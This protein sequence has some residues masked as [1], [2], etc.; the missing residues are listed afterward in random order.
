[1]ENL[2]YHQCNGADGWIA[3]PFQRSN[4]ATGTVATPANA[5]AGAFVYP[6]LLIEPPS[7]IPCIS[8]SPIETAVDPDTGTRACGPKVLHLQIVL[9][10]SW[11]ISAL[12]PTTVVTLTGKVK[13]RAVTGS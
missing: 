4:K 5:I 3:D 7:P 12:H 9:D 6:S 2:S 10:R 11:S 13:Q 1:M 8:Q